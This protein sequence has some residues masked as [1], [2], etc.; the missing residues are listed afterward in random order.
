MGKIGK[1]LAG[2]GCLFWLVASVL[3]AVLMF[4]A[5]IIVNLVGP[6]IGSLVSI[7]SY[8]TSCCSGLGF[9]SFIVGV[10]LILVGGGSAPVEE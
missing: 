5:G 3:T 4:G 10:V 9:L 8:L 1:I 2:G 7:V 6:E